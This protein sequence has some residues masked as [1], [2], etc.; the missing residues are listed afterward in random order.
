MSVSGGTRRHRGYGR[1][2]LPLIKVANTP[3]H[4]QGDGE[5]AAKKPS[6][7]EC[8]TTKLP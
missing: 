8:Q 1:V 5:T 7:L 3:F 6:C 2:Y 4:I